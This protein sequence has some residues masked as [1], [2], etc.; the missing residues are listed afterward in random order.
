VETQKL[1]PNPKKIDLNPHP[2]NFYTLPPT[3]YVQEKSLQQVL[4]KT[5]RG[6]D[7]DIKMRRYGSSAHADFSFAAVNH[8]Y[9]GKPH[10]HNNNLEPSRVI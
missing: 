9:E 1:L 4:T 6:N 7:R 3:H 8:T 5:K 2:T 10:R